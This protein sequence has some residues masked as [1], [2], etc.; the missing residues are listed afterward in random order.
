ML[1]SLAWLAAVVLLTGCAAL[2]PGKRDARDPFERAN[3]TVYKFNTAADRAVLRPAAKVWQALM[4][5]PVRTGLGNFSNNL[6]Y[7]TTIL[8]EYLQGKGRDGTADIARLVVNTI[9]GL[10]FFDPA[11]HIGLPRHN[12]DFGQTLGKWGVHPGAYLMLPILGPATVRDAP[13]RMVDAYTSGGQYLNDQYFRWS[14]SVASTLEIRT[15]LL[16]TDGM[17]ESSYDPYA[18]T[19]NAWLK[20]REY[21]VRDGNV[22]WDDATAPDSTGSDDAPPLEEPPDA[23]ADAPATAPGDAPAGVPPASDAAGAAPGGV[24]PAAN[25]AR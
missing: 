4:P 6:G 17:L 20:R 3:R 10:G 15:Q 22:E 16:A 25:P 1:K 13:A 11:S 19:R 12:E 14:L 2:P 18:L 23:P 21:E 7:P 9:F 8:N 24:T 5:R